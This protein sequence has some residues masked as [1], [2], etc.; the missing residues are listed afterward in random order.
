M[1]YLV[2]K[3]NQHN[4]VSPQITSDSLFMHIGLNDIVDILH[5]IFSL[6]TSANSLLIGKKIVKKENA[7][8][9][10]LTYLLDLCTFSY[11]FIVTIWTDIYRLQI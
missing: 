2:N 6:K 11:L 8:F 3:K 7:F 5:V 10:Y 4:K 9:V 1:R